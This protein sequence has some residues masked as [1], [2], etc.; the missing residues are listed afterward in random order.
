MAE[1]GADWLHL[2][3]MDGRYVPNITFGPHVLRAVRNI[4]SGKLDVHLMIESPEHH[5]EA[6]AAAGADY[7][8]VHPA[9]CPH[10][11]RVM[12]SIREAGAGAG[13]ALNPGVEPGVLRYV[14][15][16]TDLVLLMSVN[17]G[18]GGQKFIETTYEKIRQVNSLFDSSGNNPLLS[19]DGGVNEKNAD[20]LVQAGV[21]VLVTGSALFGAEDPGSFIQQMKGAG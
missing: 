8:T 12:G 3:V 1:A 21:N 9:A 18:F 6:F 20:R 19:V 10:L 2:D 16:Q 15:D 5:V 4:W 13:V 17:P 14:L 7:I 11:H